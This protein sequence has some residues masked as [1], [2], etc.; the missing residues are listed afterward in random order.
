MHDARKRKNVETEHTVARAAYEAHVP[1]SHT[2]GSLGDEL[3][4]VNLRL[5]DDRGR[6]SLVRNAPSY[7]RCERL[8][9]HAQFGHWKTTTPIAALRHDRLTAPCVFD[10][11]INGEK[12]SADV[13]QVLVQTLQPGDLV[14]MDNLNSHK[15]AG[16]RQAIEA[17]GGER[18]FLSAC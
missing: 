17:A 15:V 6:H 1:A 18:R 11:P 3:R 5:L 9:A 16:V 4:E 13:E 8:I 2:L 7:D 10:G 14:V 12:F